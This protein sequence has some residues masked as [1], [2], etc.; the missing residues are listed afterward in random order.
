MKLTEYQRGF[1]EAL[2]DI[3]GRIFIEYT[4]N[5]EKEKDRYYP[6]VNVILKSSSMWLL[7]KARDM[8]GIR[9]G[10]NKKKDMHTLTLG[11]LESEDLL[12]QITLV[13]REHR[14]LVALEIIEIEK[15]WG[16]GFQD[17]ITSEHSDEIERL[18]R[19][20]YTQKG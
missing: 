2:V 3:R 18:L 19:K 16:V 8:L 17:E 12:R 13:K 5:R 9:K 20:F 1:L 11:A 4:G 6:I 14:R 7:E 15:K 10:F